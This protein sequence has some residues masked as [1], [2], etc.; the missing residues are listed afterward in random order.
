VN[1][2]IIRH[3][4]CTHALAVND[5]S[6]LDPCKQAGERALCEK[7]LANIVHC[8]CHSL[9]QQSRYRFSL[10]HTGAPQPLNNKIVQRKAQAS[11]PVI[12]E[13]LE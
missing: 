12:V 10:K 7:R 8:M 6:A 1:I 11:D 9:D 3:S 5:V 4:Y 13:L 2:Q